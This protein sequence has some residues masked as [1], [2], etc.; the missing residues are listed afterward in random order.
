MNSRG[1]EKS[2]SQRGELLITFVKYPE[3]G[4]VKTRLSESIGPEAAA[5]VYKHMA[6]HVMSMLDFPSLPENQ[7]FFWDGK[8]NEGKVK[9]WLGEGKPLMRQ[10][11]RDLGQKMKAAFK[12]AFG[13]GA[14][15]VALIGSD[16]PGVSPAVIRK[17][18]RALN[19]ADVVLG[20]C[21]DGG[22]YLIAL[23]EHQPHLFSEV[24]W[25]ADKVLDTTLKK[26]AN[27]NLSTKLLKELMDVDTYSDL[28][29]YVQGNKKTL[30]REKFLAMKLAQFLPE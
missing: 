26:A 16:C 5:E 13:R 7:F 29:K 2:A 6:G 8:V 28:E 27:K 12:F 4:K 11:G 21:E 25:G 10:K 20:P 19:S 1:S 3:P 22:Y 23:K 24:N 30:G 14:S 18:F 17:A 15:K 9:Q